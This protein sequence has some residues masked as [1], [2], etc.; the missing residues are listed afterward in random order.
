MIFSD[1]TVIGYNALS[2][3][4]AH[5]TAKFDLCTIARP[6]EQYLS[7]CYIY[8]FTYHSRNFMDGQI[9]GNLALIFYTPVAY[10]KRSDIE[11]KQPNSQHVG[12]K[13][14]ISLNNK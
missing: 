3:G 10:M 5:S 7:S 6:S 11:T 4:I 2:K 13:K 12:N 9:V 14:N 8:D 1:I